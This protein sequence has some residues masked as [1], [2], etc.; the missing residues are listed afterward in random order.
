M[1]MVGVIRERGGRES[2]AETIGA[3]GEGG[4]GG[5]GAGVGAEAEA[6]AG[7]GSEIVVAEIVR[8]LVRGLGESVGT[9]AEVEAGATAARRIGQ[10]I[11]MAIDR[12]IGMSTV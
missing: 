1:V 11:E 5:V 3:G 8:N 2:P 4:I 9:V 10:G 12:E 6:G 7:V